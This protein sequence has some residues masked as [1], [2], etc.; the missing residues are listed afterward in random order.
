MKQYCRYCNNAV[1]QDDDLIYWSAKNKI[2]EKQN[3]V[4][5]NKCKAFEFNELDVFDIERKYKERKE[6][7]NDGQQIE[8]R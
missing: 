1:L 7:V 4:N 6:K 3:C 5:Q 8:M 2:K